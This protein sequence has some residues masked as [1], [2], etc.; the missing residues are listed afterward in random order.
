M[1]LHY[2]EMHAELFQYS[3]EYK[4]IGKP[5]TSCILVSRMLIP[6]L[7]GVPSLGGEHGKP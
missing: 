5:S 2:H 6:A 7:A 1:Q 4:F 3:C